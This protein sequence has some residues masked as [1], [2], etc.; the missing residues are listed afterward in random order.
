LKSIPPAI[1]V[2]HKV[3][4]LC[5]TGGFRLNKWSSKIRDL[6][7]CIPEEER[8]KDLNMLNFDKEDLHTECALGVTWLP[9]SD[10]FCFNM[11]IR[12]LPATRGNNLSIVGSLFDPLC[13]TVYSEDKDYSP[14]FV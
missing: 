8:A 3:T 2:Y 10:G 9:K 4:A 6:L 5:A 11:L 7:R 12:D 13:F 14:G 1:D